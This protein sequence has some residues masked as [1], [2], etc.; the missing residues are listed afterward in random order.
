MSELALTTPTDEDGDTIFGGF[1]VE[2][3]QQSAEQILESMREGL[4]TT[5]ISF[6]R[7]AAAVHV[8][9]EKGIEVARIRAAMGP[10]TNYLRMI[11]AGNLRPSVVCRFWMNPDLIRRIGRIP[12]TDQKKLAAGGRVPM[13]VIS[14]TGGTTVRNTDPGEMTAEQLKQV[15][16][17]DHIRT[18]QEQAAWLD[19]QRTEAAKPVGEVFGPFKLDRIR[20]GAVFTGKRGDLIDRSTIAALH[21]A[22]ANL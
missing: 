7:H 13:V 16:A 19:G 4:R 15:F 18:E 9:E 21:R 12:G 5:T 22:M 10:V 20:G 14:P 17:K 2:F 1:L 3:R 6:I 11:A 8:L